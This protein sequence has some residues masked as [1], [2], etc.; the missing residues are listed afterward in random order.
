M[1][2]LLLPFICAFLLLGCA[3]APKLPQ[4]QA[5]LSLDPIQVKTDIE[6]YGLRVD[7]YRVQPDV[8]NDT[9]QAA[10]GPPNPASDP[11]KYS[12]IG[13][14]L[15]N[16]LFEDSHGNI[17]VDLVRLY[18]IEEP[19]HL[20]E[21]IAGLIPVKIDFRQKDGVFQRKGGGSDLPNV[22]AEIGDDS[23]ELTFSQPYSKASIYR[24]EEDV[25]FDGHGLLGSN[26]YGLHQASPRRISRQG[27]IGS[28]EFTAKND[29]EAALSSKFLMKRKDKVITIQELSA[30]SNST[31]P[32]Q[33]VRTE[34]GCIFSDRG[35]NV[36][37][38]KRA[39]DTITVSRNSKLNR[40]YT[41]LT[42]ASDN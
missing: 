13:I 18:G 37:E 25:T 38:V 32:I 22:T 14:D 33:Y 7:V 1:K 24:D 9:Q 31:R 23:L 34:S 16:G 10:G 35:G 5:W 30:L 39:G 41:I 11:S 28:I 42:A 4:T 17:A 20:E 2:N 36:Y 29:N 27:L 26:K 3:S 12:W 19:F 6:F 15:G 21:V 40:T 8:N